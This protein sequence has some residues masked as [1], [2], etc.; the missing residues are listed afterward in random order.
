MSQYLTEAKNMQKHNLHNEG[1]YMDNAWNSLSQKEKA[2]MI[3]V[4]IQNGIITLPEI[5]KA[6]NEFAKGGS[7]KGWT[8]EDEAGYRYW[9]QNLPKNLRDTNDNDYDM[10]AAYKAGMQ[11]EWNDEDKSY[12]LGSRDPESG[13][14]LKSIHHPTFIKALV[15]DAKLGYYP[16][17][18][19]KG[20]VY[21][22][23]WEGNKY[24]NGGY[25]P[26]KKLRQDIA[27]WEGSSMK[28]NRS[29]EDEAK[30]FNRVIP[31]EVR[32]KLSSNQLDA[33]FSYGY[34]VGMG[35]LKERVLPTLTAYTHGKASNEDVQ[36]SMWASKDN[37]LRGLTRRRNWERE[38][39]GGNYRS[40][41]TGTGLG[42]HM[43]P[44]L[45]NLSPETSAN[46]DSMINTSTLQLPVA[47]DPEFKYKAPAIDETLFQKPQE[48]TVQ[49]PV[50]APQQDRLEGLRNFNTV[51]GLIGQQSPFAALENSS[52]GLL[53][54]I[55]QI[56]S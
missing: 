2:E 31:A 28:T 34:N 17:M 44:T 25:A 16:T 20:H 11:P 52:P 19:D 27:T 23:T 12:H 50:Y 55:G 49:E 45:L 39:F 4:A 36:R 35:R 18:D 56:Y 40:Q 24:G 42:H 32:N 10:R 43:D 14:I 1:G 29:F 15:E 21:T 37:V 26:S 8:M 54:Y 51:M 22:E 5:K 48:E 46:I 6:Y 3:K 38:M 9:R 47:E 53:S 33:L 13:R 30:D 7:M 41:F